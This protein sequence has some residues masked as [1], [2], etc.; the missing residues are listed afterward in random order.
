M[1]V[2][3]L[4]LPPLAAALVD[5]GVTNGHV[6]IETVLV[7]TIA[8]MLAQRS[9]KLDKKP[10]TEK[11]IDQL[12]EEWAPQPLVPPL[13]EQ[14]TTMTA[15]VLLGA[16]GPRVKL[17]GEKKELLNFVSQNFLG[18]PSNADVQEA[19][20]AAI[21]K[22]GVGSCGPRGFYGT[23]DVH[24]QLEE[25]L[26]K[27]MG[28]D[29]GILY[30]YDMATVASTLPTFAKRGDLLLV[31]EG[32]NYAVQN[33]VSLSR[34]EV[35]WFKHN[36][37]AD[38]ER[39]LN[40]VKAEDARSRKPLNRRFIVVEG[41]YANHG[42]VAPLKELVRLKESFFFRLVV[43]ESVSFGSLP[44]G[45]GRGAC[46]YAGVEPGAADIVCGSLGNS[47]GSVG[48]F[49][50]GSHEV[51]A[52]QR[53]NASGYVFSAS[54]PPFLASGAIAGLRVL[55]QQPELRE[56]LAANAAALRKALAGLP[57]SV[58]TGDAVS[59]LLHLRLAP[60]VAADSAAGEAILQRVC[61]RA[62]K[63][64][65]L[66]IATAKYSPL[67]R[68]VPPP[69]IRIAVSARHTKQDIADAA[70]AICAAWAAEVRA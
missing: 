8:F 48:G 31:D 10:L 55:E 19:C 66:L 33:G 13:S 61:D 34:S 5:F 11:E 21:E 42:D 63:E 38:L 29:E 60:G 27:F 15:P 67:E 2:T 44:G 59:P 4:G 35:R 53:I 3:A 32:V 28:T 20:R 14:A 47:L 49:C 26:A 25:A 50:V 23:I 41:I 1:N 57:G 51:I 9:Y 37:M 18:M 45:A 65:G 22:Y 56:E 30:S 12:C 39:L 70:A 46:E 52:H 40:E 43:D 36:D 64:N 54:L 62:K 68:R 7:A 24:L 6:V 58:L 69:S 16:T 17:A